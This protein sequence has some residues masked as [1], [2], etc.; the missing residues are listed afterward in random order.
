[1][2]TVC[3][4]DLLLEFDPARWSV[5]KWDDHA[6]YLEGVARLNGQLTDPGTG[7]AVPEGSKAVDILALDEHALHFI[8]V[9]DFRGHGPQ[10]AFRQETE[11]PLE[12][13]LKV[14]DT[15]AGML[16][17]HRTHR[18]W[19]AVEPFV[20]ALH[21]RRFPVRVIAWILEDSPLGK[22]DRRKQ[23]AVGSVRLGQ[24]RSR[25]SWLTEQVW[26]DD[27]FHP[28]VP[29]PGVHVSRP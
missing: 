12:V 22:K 25:L 20:Q 8:E 10:N 17:A 6:L 16:G 28:S 13:G 3:E 19:P 5:L 26:V 24:L 27:P 14:R 1:M 15:L 18:Q 2:T 4:G 7:V 11:L 29:L 21:E 23:S 9:K